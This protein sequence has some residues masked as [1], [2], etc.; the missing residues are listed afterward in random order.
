MTVASSSRTFTATFTTPVVQSSDVF[1][2]TIQS[3]AHTPFYDVG[4][5]GPGGGIVFY[6]KDEGFS[7]GPTYSSTGSPTGGLCHY[8]EVAPSGWSGVSA[9]PTRNWSTGTSG[10]GNA[11]TD[12]P[13]IANDS[14]AYNNVLGIG[15]GYKNSI[16]IISQNGVGTTYAAGLARAYTGGSKSDWYL[17]STT[18]LNLICQWSRGVVSS[19]TNACTGGTL[20]SATYGA[21]GAG[22]AARFWSSSE[23][24]QFTAWSQDLGNGAQ[25]DGNKVPIAAPSIRPIRA[26]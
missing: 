7:C 3:A 13:T 4:G 12:V 14:T 1:R 2:V 22:L 15:L 18:E 19:V 20:N 6:V 25:N 17:P 8:L 10:V 9:D 26:F 11:R 24:T 23:A 5:T 21:S 16:A